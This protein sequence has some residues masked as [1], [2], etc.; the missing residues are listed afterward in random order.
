MLATVVAVLAAIYFG[1][2]QLLWATQDAREPPAIETALPFISP[3]LGV[4]RWGK[5]YTVQLRDRTRAPITTLRLPGFRLYLI[6]SPQLVAAVQRQTK[7]LTFQAMQDSFA[8]L[9]CELSPTAIAAQDR[10]TTTWMNGTTQS[11]SHI[12][13]KALL[14]GKHLD[15]MN[16]VM[17]EMLLQ[18]VDSLVGSGEGYTG[19]LFEWLK[20]EITVATTEGIYGPG[21]PYRDAKVRDAYWTYDSGV[22]FLCLSPQLAVAAQTARR[23]LAATWCTYYST[24]QHLRGSALIQQRH[25][26]L[27]SEG[28]PAAD[29]AA[30]EVGNGIAILSN[31]VPTAFWL[32]YHIFSNPAIYAACH[33][34]VAAHVVTSP[35]SDPSARTRTLDISALKSACPLLLSTL[36]EVLRTY[37]VGVGLRYVSTDHLLGGIHLL[38]QG[39][40]VV[41][42]T[43]VQHSDPSLW[44]A[45]VA[46]FDY[47]RFAPDAETQKQRARINPM[48]F[49]AFGGGS[50][51]CPGRHFATTEVLVLVAVLLMRFE[52]RPAAG[53]HKGSQSTAWPV[54]TIKK[55]RMTSV[56]PGPDAD[57]RVAIAQK[58]EDRG[59]KW[60][61]ELSAGA[62]GVVLAAEDGDVEI[63]GREGGREGVI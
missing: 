29:I 62:K 3:I 24:S 40:T 43:A 44:G 2:R 30:L 39:A 58:A 41:M 26:W 11:P 47:T 15:D 34:E 37:A 63:E 18:R 55:A 38:K 4:L 19:G 27:T 59:V 32:V 6:N 28:F 17:V 51:A 54:A 10:T 14:P 53:A 8:R 46:A 1:L 48:A 25:A 57:V 35:S 45:D 61:W 36:K 21:N 22:Q 16:R 13:Y 31:T 56:M 9:I 50:T 33:A 52:V 23:F 5:D 12:I 20:R 7:L 49:R 42:P 60:V